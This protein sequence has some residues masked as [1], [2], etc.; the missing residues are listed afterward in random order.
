[1]RTTNAIESPFATVRARTR[2]TKGAGSR[3]AALTMA[4]KLLTQAERRWRR[5]NSPHLAALV[6]AGV[7]FRDGKI[8]ILPDL[9]SD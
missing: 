1:L 2:T 3:D 7:R 6:L 5:I 9:P 4:F 8:D